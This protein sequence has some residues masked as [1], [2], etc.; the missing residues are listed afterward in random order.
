MNMPPKTLKVIFL[1]HK[2]DKDLGGNSRCHW[3]TIRTKNAANLNVAHILTLS[4]LSDAG[5]FASEF[6]THENSYPLTDA[7][8][9]R[10]ICRRYYSGLAKEWDKDNL[11]GAFKGYLD[12]VSAA[13]VTNDLK[14][15]PRVEQLKVKEGSWLEVE[16]IPNWALA[17][18]N[19]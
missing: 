15:E 6:L 19:A 2:A 8:P 12:G 7:M 13:L 10:I 1:N 3:R 18:V 17:G 4:A 11:I 16:I 9:I 14:F 5:T